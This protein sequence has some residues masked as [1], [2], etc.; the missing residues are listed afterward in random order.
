MARSS[1][2]RVGYTGIIFI[3]GM[4]TVVF[5]ILQVDLPYTPSSALL[6]YYK[7]EHRES[8][9]ND[10][11]TDVAEDD[12]VTADATEGG[13]DVAG[14]D[15]SE[16]SAALSDS[17]GQVV[18][19]YNEI[20]AEGAEAE[21]RSSSEGE[22]GDLESIPEEA[23]VSQALAV[24]AALAS[25]IETEPRI[26]ETS[27]SDVAISRAA[28]GEDEEGEASGGLQW[29]ELLQTQ[30][31]ALTMNMGA[32][33][34]PTSEMASLSF[35][36][37]RH[38]A[39]AAP[40]IVDIESHFLPY[41]PKLDFRPRYGRCA[42]V[43]NSG[44]NLGT[45]MGDEIDSHDAVIRINYAPTRGFERDVGSK[46]TLDLCNKE[47][48]LG[49]VKG[50]HKWRDSTLVLFEA[51]SR[52]IRKNV[53]SKLFHM[54]KT[55]QEHPVVML[56]PALVTTSRSIYLAI[57]R[58]LEQEV[59]DALHPGGRGEGRREW[60]QKMLAAKVASSPPG[61][62]DATREHFEFHAK[63]MSGMVALYLALQVCDE[64]SMYG[65]DA[66]TEKTTTRYHYFDTR[67]AMTWVHSFDLAV[68]LYKR[69]GQHAKVKMRP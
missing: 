26:S 53:Y 1:S 63:P 18:V 21:E 51:H 33:Q 65:F 54:F 69:I 7:G 41:L 31:T 35:R 24:E 68:E 30:K 25:T 44:A 10:I 58:E 48:T 14:L 29:W 15:L 52:I 6:R 36:D 5:R 43:G 23:S 2:P 3:L 50:T 13:E 9:A 19:A 67:V 28:E 20:Q 16:T 61:S 39:G 59:R 55:P 47:N 34:Q 17:D 40:R 27:R 62:K 66:Y 46:T 56:N 64:V 45:G 12:A 22:E 60:A 42:V 4:L 37:P 49:L 8:D 38:E 11:G 32:V 57:K